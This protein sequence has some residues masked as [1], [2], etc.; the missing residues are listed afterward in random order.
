MSTSF[1]E[2]LYTAELSNG[3]R[4]K[5]SFAVYNDDAL[6]AFD[7]IGAEQVVKAFR[8][9]VIRQA[10]ITSDV[11]VYADTYETLEYRIEKQL[12]FREPPLHRWLFYPAPPAASLA[13]VIFGFAGM[14]A[15]PALRAVLQTTHYPTW[16]GCGAALLEL[17]RNLG[18]IQ[19]LEHTANV[20][21]AYLVLLTDWLD[22]YGRGL[23]T[24]QLDIAAIQA[25]LRGADAPVDARPPEIRALAMN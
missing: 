17:G 1:T 25:A 10:Q 9:S 8:A 4:G 22:V 11:G 12:I 7:I 2:Q 23:E 18:K 15:G 3:A 16:P 20:D 6:L 5:L 13:R 14:G 19:P 21:F 24:G